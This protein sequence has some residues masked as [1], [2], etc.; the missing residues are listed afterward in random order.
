MISEEKSPLTNLAV[1]G[2]LEKMCVH[3]VTIYFSLERDEN[4]KEKKNQRD[5][6]YVLLIIGTGVQ[7]A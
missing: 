1:D 7:K 4:K 6:W 3:S 5:S 2:L